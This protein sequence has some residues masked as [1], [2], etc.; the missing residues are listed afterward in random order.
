MK[1]RESLL[2]QKIN[3]ALPKAHL[4]RI[5]SNTLQGIPDINGVWS[6]KSFW[7]E[8]K[9]DKSSFPMRPSWRDA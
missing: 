8:L 3:K 4:T 2:W 6:T 1:K 7:I 9:S 5:E